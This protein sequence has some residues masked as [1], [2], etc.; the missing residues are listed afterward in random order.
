MIRQTKKER[1]S[2]VNGLLLRSDQ[3]LNE[4][5]GNEVGAK[6]TGL[7]SGKSPRLFFKPCQLGNMIILPTAL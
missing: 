1:N 6:S 7:I 5:G 4:S 3:V 2:P